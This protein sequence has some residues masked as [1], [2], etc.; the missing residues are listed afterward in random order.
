MA[1]K[2][3][4]KITR[5]SQEAWKLVQKQSASVAE[6]PPPVPL[7][8]CAKEFGIR[9]IRFEPIISAAGLAKSGEDLEIIVNTEAVEDTYP[10]GTTLAI[11]DVKWAVFAPS[12]R[13]TIAHE[14]AH[15]A[16]F[17]TTGWD[18]ESD[19]AQKNRRHIERACNILARTFLM[20]RKMLLQGTGNRLFDVAHVESLLSAF[21]V[22]PEVFIR[23]LHLSDVKSCYT[24]LDGFLAFAQEREGRVRIKACHVVGTHA[25]GRFHQ[26]LGQRKGESQQLREP[27][28]LSVEYLESKWAM[29]GWA[30]NDLKLNG[31]MDLESFLR[32]N[33]NGRLIF[34]VGWAAGDV[35]PC[36]LTFRRIHHSRLGSLLRVQVTG[37][38]QKPG[39]K[40]LF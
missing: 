39:Q 40:S 22:S 9:C 23:R 28:G 25:K 30:I 2:S 13:F 8:N 4:A 34:E 26:A 24:E 21:R 20:P 18:K 37:P 11:D 38:V 6:W 1:S 36:D 19:L 17:R 7:G 35:I 32:D 10:P 12:L 31:D 15:A 3:P 16:F 29:E 33:E 27:S 5:V 14:I